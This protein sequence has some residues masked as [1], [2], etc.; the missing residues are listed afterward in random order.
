MKQ[1]TAVLFCSLLTAVWPIAD[2]SGQMVQLKT[3]EVLIGVVHDAH[4]DGLEVQRLDNG[5]VLE[6]TW[7][8]LSPDSAGRIK[9]LWNLSLDDEGEVMCN[10]H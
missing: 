10:V 4:E 8:Q 1:R 7:D 6:L 9:T 3:G 2:V 5:G